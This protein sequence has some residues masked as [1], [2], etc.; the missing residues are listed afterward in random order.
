[1]R[2]LQIT[3]AYCVLSNS[4]HPVLEMYYG[5]W[6]EKF[7][8]HFC[9]NTCK[10]CEYKCKENSCDVREHCI[11]HIPIIMKVSLSIDANMTLYLMQRDICIFEDV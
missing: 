6:V 8:N 2:F 4:K 11:L 9:S 10:Y 1:M 5:N 7:F 3:N